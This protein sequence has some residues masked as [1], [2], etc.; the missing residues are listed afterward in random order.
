[1]ND[2]ILELN[3]PGRE[4]EV[5]RQEAEEL[6]AFDETALSEEVARGAT[7]LEVLEEETQNGQVEE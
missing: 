1:M 7:V 3:I 2:K 4:I 6:G 5:S